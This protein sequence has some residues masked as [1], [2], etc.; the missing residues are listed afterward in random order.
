MKTVRTKIGRAAGAMALGLALA[1][2]AACS[3]KVQVL[4]APLAATAVSPGNSAATG[5]TIGPFNTNAVVLVTADGA[6]RYLGRPRNSGILVSILNGRMALAQDDSFEGTSTNM[7]YQA[8]T[9]YN[10]FL[11]RGQSRRINARTDHFGFGSAANRPTR[12]R[13][14]AIA[15]AAK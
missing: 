12:V 2:T 13:M 15:M 1:A 10:F 3:N 7:I 11:P 14:T 8:A 6:S 4:N 5:L 9:S